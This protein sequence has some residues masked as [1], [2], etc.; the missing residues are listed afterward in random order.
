MRTC[1]HSGE[2][3][4]VSARDP[5][6]NRITSGRRNYP[7][8]RGESATADTESATGGVRERDTRRGIE[9]RVTIR[10]QIER[11]SEAKLGN[12]PPCSAQCGFESSCRRCDSDPVET[13]FYGIEYSRSRLF[14]WKTQDDLGDHRRSGE[15]PDIV[16]ELGAGACD[17]ER[18]E[19]LQLAIGPDVNL[20][21]T[22]GEEIHCASESLARPAGASGKDRLHARLTRKQAKN[23]GS[24]EIV[25]RVKND[26]FSDERGHPSNLQTP[27]EARADEES[28]SRRRIVQYGFVSLVEH[29]LDAR[30]E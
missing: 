17:V 10:A 13:V 22:L 12:Y 26:R 11:G 27:A 23:P 25:E 2:I 6:A 18:S 15:S 16:A 9:W 1:I 4:C 14:I 28:A 30:S 7:A 24:L 29:V 8:T 21:Y 5:G 19:R 3:G 20:G